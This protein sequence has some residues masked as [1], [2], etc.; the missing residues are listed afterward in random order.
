[1]SVR[2][3][4]EY[5]DIVISPRGPAEQPRR[6]RTNDERRASL[7]G[8]FLQFAVRVEAHPLPVGREEWMGGPLG[9]V[10]R[11]H[12]EAVE[13]SQVESARSV[14][15]ADVDEMFSIARDRYR[16]FSA[17]YRKPLAVAQSDSEVNRYGRRGARREP[18]SSDNDTSRDKRQHRRFQPGKTP[19]SSLPV[20]G[21]RRSTFRRKPPQL[22]TDITRA[23]PPLVALLGETSMNDKVH[24]S[25]CRPFQRRDR[26]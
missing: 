13:T 21:L 7:D 2:L 23:L 26:N 1:M 18:E 12:F 20:R 14:V 19:R 8:H 22:P 9:A 4:C 6:R 16:C 24:R 10:E 11:A 15:V 5:D 25:R 3:G 17:I